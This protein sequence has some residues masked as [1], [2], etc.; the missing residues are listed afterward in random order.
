MF[1]NIFND[2]DSTNDYFQRRIFLVD[3]YNIC[4]INLTKNCW[5]N[6]NLKERLF[7]V[8]CICQQNGQRD[9]CKK[10]SKT[11]SKINSS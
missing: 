10:V 9:H 8:N 1:Q 7:F 2:K 3:F 6:N 5:L 4:K 11:L